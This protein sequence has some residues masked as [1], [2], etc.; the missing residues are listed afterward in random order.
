MLIVLRSI[1]RKSS[2]PILIYL[3]NLTQPN[4]TESITTHAR[5]DTL[6]NQL[7]SLP[8]CAAAAPQGRQRPSTIPFPDRPLRRQRHPSPIA[9]GPAA[10]AQRIGPADR[11]GKGASGEEGSLD[12]RWRAA[13]EGRRGEGHCLRAIDGADAVAPGVVVVERGGA[14]DEGRGAP[15]AVACCFSCPESVGG[16]GAVKVGKESIRHSLH[17]RARVPLLAY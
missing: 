15:A 9:S 6:I 13:A 14:A 3:H 11:S 7:P 2:H 1:C 17:S 16:V 4:G 8:P 12:Y 10:V 5:T